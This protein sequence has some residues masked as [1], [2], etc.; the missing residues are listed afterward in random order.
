MDHCDS[1]QDKF[2][3]LAKVNWINWP[4]TYRNEVIWNWILILTAI[5]NFMTFSTKCNFI[6]PK[7]TFLCSQL[8]HKKE[9]R[10]HSKHKTLYTELYPKCT[11]SPPGAICSPENHVHNNSKLSLPYHLIPIPTPGLILSTVTQWLRVTGGQERDRG[12]QIKRIV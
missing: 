4:W 12:G 3:N 11:Q 6:Q 8:Q 1:I 9:P 2:D 10:A 7:L 5:S